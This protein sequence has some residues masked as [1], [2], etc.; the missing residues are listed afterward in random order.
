MMGISQLGK[1]GLCRMRLA[2]SE[3]SQIEPGDSV[4]ASVKQAYQYQLSGL[5]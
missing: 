2:G 4:S 1:R 3:C 5:L